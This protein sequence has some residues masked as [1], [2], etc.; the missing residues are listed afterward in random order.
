MPR[1]AYTWSL[2][3]Q[4][5]LG[6]P[7]LQWSGFGSKS[8]ALDRSGSTSSRCGTLVLVSGVD[9]KGSFPWEIR[10]RAMSALGWRGR[11]SQQSGCG[12]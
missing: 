11:E 10:H 3:V 7:Q 5:E 6:P 1:L 2:M 4:S 8:A 12:V 9:W